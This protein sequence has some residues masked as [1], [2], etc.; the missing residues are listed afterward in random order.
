MLSDGKK[1]VR[2]WVLYFSVRPPCGYSTELTRLLLEDSLVNVGSSVNSA[3]GDLH[4]TTVHQTGTVGHSGGLLIIHAK[5]E[6][7]SPRP[8]VQ[9]MVEG[10]SR[11]YG[12]TLMR[13]PF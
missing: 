3:I 12:Y 4:S 8:V 9:Y 5:A 7:C 6:S 11:L 1:S 13:L 10:D 2:H